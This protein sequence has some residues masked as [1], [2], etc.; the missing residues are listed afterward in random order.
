MQKMS[1]TEQL[2]FKITNFI[3]NNLKINKII[4]TNDYIDI[5]W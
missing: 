5:T 2:F 1:K 4:I 3:R